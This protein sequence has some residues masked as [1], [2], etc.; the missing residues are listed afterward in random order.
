M[1][2]EKNCD[3]RESERPLRREELAKRQLCEA[4]TEKVPE[5]L[6]GMDQFAHLKPFEHSLVELRTLEAVSGEGSTPFRPNWVASI[7]RPKR[8]GFDTQPKRTL[9]HYGSELEALY[10]WRPDDRRIYNDT[11]YPWGCVCRIVTGAGTGSGVIVG[12]RHVLTASHVVDWSRNGA[13]TVEVHR[14]GASVSAITA[15]TRAWYFTQVTPPNVGYSEVDEDYAVLITADRIGD[16]FGWMGT[17]TYN[18]SWDDEPY[19]RNIGYPGDV[20]SGL[21]PIYQRDKELDEDWADW[22]SARSMTTTADTMR[23]QSGSPMFGFWS[24]GPYVV[25][26]VSAQG[27]YAL[28]GE[29]NWCSGG[30]LLTRLVNHARSADA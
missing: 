28:S 8:V 19:W 25:A 1:Y 16:R 4:A 17:R 12:P 7:E 9:H 11:S 27:T 21:F 23:G 20:A 15:I 18:S 2:K 10:V 30:N 5:H 26:V 22:G 3:E 6:R 24:N 29:E 14:A 13:G